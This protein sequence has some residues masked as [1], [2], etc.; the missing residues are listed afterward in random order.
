MSLILDALNKAE[1]DRER[2]KERE[3]NDP[4]SIKSHHDHAPLSGLGNNKLTFVYA[5][6]LILLIGLGAGAYFWSTNT[7]KLEIKPAGTE[8]VTEAPAQLQPENRPARQEKKEIVRPTKRKAEVAAL[9]EKP[10]PPPA[11]PPTPKPANP[12]V[13]KKP[14]PPAKPKEPFYLADFPQFGDIRSLPWEV[15]EAIPTLTYTE[16]NFQPNNQGHIVINGSRLKRGGRLTQEIMVDNILEDGV[17][18]RYKA[19]GFKL[20]ALSSWINM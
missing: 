19:H 11:P 15:Q 9:Y 6:G 2:E 16:H 8:R 20:Q 5:A 1:A 4:P 10:T 18:L 13:E 14:E 7:G 17:I 12:V 3:R